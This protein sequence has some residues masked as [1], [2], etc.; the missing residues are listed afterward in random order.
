[1]RI[2]LFTVSMTLTLGIAVGGRSA[3]VLAKHGEN[4][5]W[6][7]KATQRF[8]HQACTSTYA[9]SPS[10]IIICSC[11]GPALNENVTVNASVAVASGSE[12][13]EK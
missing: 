10:T 7:E 8:F 12:F 13:K 5:T 9:T 6:A 2:Q 11:V 3:V 4:V 1:M